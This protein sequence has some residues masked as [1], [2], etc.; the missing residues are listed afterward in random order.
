M[1]SACKGGKSRLHSIHETAATWP[2]SGTESQTQ[3]NL[4]A[5]GTTKLSDML[6]GHRSSR[7][8]ANRPRALDRLL[9]V[10]SHGLRVV[11]HVGMSD[12]PSNPRKRPPPDAEDS[13]SENVLSAA[14]KLH[15]DDAHPSGSAVR[16][17]DLFA[18]EPCE[19]SAPSGGAGLVAIESGGI[20]SLAG[21]V[22][23]ADGAPSSSLQSP[24]WLPRAY[25]KI[26]GSYRARVCTR[27]G[28]DIFGC[29]CDASAAQPLL[30]TLNSFLARGDQAVVHKATERGAPAPLTS[31]C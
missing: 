30:Y 25:K 4:G 19:P 8:G 29:T 26:P 31:Q 28:N 1:N 12:R 5:A 17:V 27:V 7:K 23:A 6:E 14:L 21:A 13:C 18:P 15:C 22:A 16:E 3:A 11:S 2:F 24:V 20:P 10:R 9:V